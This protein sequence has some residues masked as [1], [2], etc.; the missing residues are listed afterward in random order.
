M[1]EETVAER[2]IAVALLGLLNVK[3]FDRISISEITDKAGVYKVVGDH[4]SSKEDILIRHSEYVLDSVVEDFRS[5]RIS[6][7]YEFWQKLFS[8]L[9]E[10]NLVVNMQK[11][12]YDEAFFR[13]FESRMEIILTEV[14]DLDMSSKLNIVFMEFFIGGLTSLLR[15]PMLSDRKISAEDV[16]RFLSLLQEQA[17]IFSR[18]TEKKRKINV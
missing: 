11:A 3:S 10:T 17:V 13:I 4:F 1:P 8:E 6:N 16:E 5:G 12:G 9:S 18:N 7:G 2:R 15:K 14:M